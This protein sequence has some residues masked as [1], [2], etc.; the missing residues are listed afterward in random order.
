MF[1]QLWNLQEPWVKLCFFWLFIIVC[2]FLPPVCPPAGS[3]FCYPKS[4]NFCV[5]EIHTK[6]SVTDIFFPPP[7]NVVQGRARS[8]M[9]LFLKECTFFAMGKKSCLVLLESPVHRLSGTAQSEAVVS[10][11]AR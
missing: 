8:E 11:P 5:A 10:N 6:K 4:L 2:P 7:V 9:T 1:L 3:C